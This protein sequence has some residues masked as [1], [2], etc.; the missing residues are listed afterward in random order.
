MDFYAFGNGFLMEFGNW[1]EATSGACSGHRSWHLKKKKKMEREKLNENI[2]LYK[3][4]MKIVF[5]C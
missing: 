4:S 3:Q 1:K 2:Y 5:V